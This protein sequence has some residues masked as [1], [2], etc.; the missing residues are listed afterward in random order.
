M[1][2]MK[3][4]RLICFFAVLILFSC[5]TQS[6]NTKK[7]KVIIS[8]KVLNFNPE[9]PKVRITVNRLGFLGT[10]IVK[11][12][13][14]LGNF[15]AVFDTYIP[16]DAWI[17]YQTNFLV[18]TH[19]GDSIYVEFNGK[20]DRRPDILKTIKFSGDADKQN[21][22]AAKL[23]L[24]YYSNPVYYDFEAKQKAIK[25]LD[26]AAYLNYLD[27]LRTILDNMFRQFISEVEADA[28]TKIWAKFFLDENYYSALS[29]YPYDHRR[30]NG[31][32][33]SE[34]SVPPTFY[35]PLKSRLPISE[36]MFISGYALSS[37]INRYHYYYVLPKVIEERKNIRAKT[38][39]MSIS[40]S[41]R[42]YDSL[43]VSGIIKYTPDTL[44]RQ[45]V[46]T[47]LFSQ[48]FN[49]SEVRLFENYKNI[50]DAYIKRPFLKEPLFDRYQKLKEY[51]EN[52]QIAS[53]AQIKNVND[54]TAQQ[55]MDNIIDSN[56]GKVIYLDCW[57]T[58]CGPC[59]SE[60]PNSKELMKKM[61]GKDIAFVYLCLDSEKRIW[62]ASLAELQISGQQ[63]FLNKKQSK[64]FR[65]TY[66]VHGIPHYFLIDK[67]GKITE[68]GSHLRPNRVK[69][70]IESLL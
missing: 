27:S 13:D 63:Y 51:L 5:A 61:R 4:K 15:K 52:P 65:S 37:F 59:K 9:N 35:E 42:M 16:T 55:I 17:T 28:E 32:K 2:C 36:S 26:T 21:K 69:E 31:L 64:D 3:M 41:R 56:K 70:K 39:D 10:Q 34:W 19:P 43:H 29:F 48:N 53:D 6:N 47:E 11:Q 23:Q 18:L 7:E 45:M 20:P 49:K 24:L 54:F 33:N 50:A 8:G 40:D 22:D 25:E 14:S 68:K 67:K 58:W 1:E 12:L 30:A 57:A 38:N 46:L 44:L 62:K 66:D 60:M